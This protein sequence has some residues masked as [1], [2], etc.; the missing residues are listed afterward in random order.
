MRTS[1]VER[2]ATNTEGDRDVMKDKRVFKILRAACINLSL[3]SPVRLIRT[4]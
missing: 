1:H 3:R 4:E 2:Y